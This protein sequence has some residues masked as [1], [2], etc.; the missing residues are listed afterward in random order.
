MTPVGLGAQE[1]ER[2]ARAP[3]R[4]S[5]DR[6]RACGSRAASPTRRAISICAR[7]ARA[8]VLARRAVAVEVEAG[9]TDR[10]DPRVRAPAP[11]SARRPRRRTRRRRSGGGRPRRTPPR[12]A[13]AAAI[14]SRVRRLVD[15]D[16]EDPPHPDP[17]RVGDQLASSGLGKGRGGSACRSRGECLGSLRG[18]GARSR[19]RRGRPPP[20]N[21]RATRAPTRLRTAARRRRGRARPGRP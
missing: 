6:R 11:R 14:A 15:A 16:G 2:L 3:R 5:S 21:R 19:R 8:L 13:S 12:G 18:R 10:R 7:K 4:R 1:L 9:L 20:P 17:A